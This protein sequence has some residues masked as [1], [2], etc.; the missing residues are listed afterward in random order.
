MV[1]DLNHLPGG[2]ELRACATADRP[3]L[4]E[5]YA[6]ARADE[7]RPVPW[8]DE[9]KAAFVK[10]QF[11]AQDTAYRL[12]YPT[13]EFLLIVDHSTPI[14]RLYLGRLPGELRIIDLTLSPGRRGRGIGT[15]LVERVLARADRERLVVTLHVEPWNPARRLYERLGFE[16]IELRGVY[17]FMRRHPPAQLKTAS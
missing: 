2:I 5:L 17:E 14:G 15:A 10:M 7:L 8:A 13:G 11:D 6:S 1:D 12:A 3:F 16:S 9:E 4:L